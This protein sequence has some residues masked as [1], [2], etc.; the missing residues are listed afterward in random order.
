MERQQIANQLPEMYAAVVLVGLIGYLMNLGLRCPSAPD[1]LLVGRGAIGAMTT[2]RRRRLAGTALGVLVFIAALCV[3]EVWARAAD[4]FLVPTASEVAEQA[5]EIW[6]TSEFLS[7]AGA[8][9]KRLAVGFA[10]AAAIGIGLGLLVGA[11]QAARR[12]LDP[13]LELLRA[14]PAIA[15]VPAAIVILGLG[16]A[17][18]IAVIAFGLCFPILVNTAEGVRLIPPE[19]RDTASMLHVGRVERIFRVYFPAALPSI[20]AGLRIAVSI[21]LVLVVVSEFVGEG[22]GL[23]HYLLVQRS[24]L[25]GS[26]DVRRHPLPRPARV[27]PQPALPRR[28]AP[29]PRLA[30]R[31]G[32]WAEPVLRVEG[33]EKR[34]SDDGPAAS[35]RRHVRRGRGGVRC[36]R[37]S[38]GLRQDDAPP[39]ALRA[40]RAE[41]RHRPPRRPPRHLAAAGS[42][43][44][45]PGLLPVPDAVA[46][47]GGTLSDPCRCASRR[48]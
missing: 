27:R 6:R 11:S 26:G 33:L 37:R 44:R 48:P 20:M 41:R 40:D 22:N 43:D 14:V 38:V 19:V 31:S 39:A 32:R 24:L 16:D 3:W 46:L 35:E 21:G 23:G 2:S 10:I 15:I 12:T 4:S 5:W 13:F 42:R 7:E 8:S 47:G 18:R 9:L 29:G 34:Y 17:Q 36:D 25:R 28:R 30:L 1:A 45:L